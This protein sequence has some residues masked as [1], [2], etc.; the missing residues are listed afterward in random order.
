MSD[1]EGKRK[2]NQDEDVVYDPDYVL[3]KH[4]KFEHLYIGKHALSKSVTCACAGS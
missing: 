1:T 4:K 2:R 3:R